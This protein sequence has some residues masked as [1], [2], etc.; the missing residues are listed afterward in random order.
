VWKRIGIARGMNGGGKPKAQNANFTLNSGKAISGQ[1]VSP[2]V[3]M[4]LCLFENDRHF[5]GYDKRLRRPTTAPF[6]ARVA[7]FVLGRYGK[8][9]AATSDSGEWRV[10]S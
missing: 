8:L 9:P 7:R 5:A 2:A 6:L 4:E 10:N 1:E 3:L